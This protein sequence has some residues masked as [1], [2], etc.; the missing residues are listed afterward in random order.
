MR[1]RDVPQF[2][3]VVVL[4]EFV[5]STRGILGSGPCFLSSDT[6]LPLSR[7]WAP[8]QRVESV[9][10]RLEVRNPSVAPWITLALPEMSVFFAVLHIWIARRILFF[11][12]QNEGVELHGHS[13]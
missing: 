13:R 12:I 8:F 9:I 1:T 2:E 11:L 4:D 6:P 10:S 5:V 7:E 3:P